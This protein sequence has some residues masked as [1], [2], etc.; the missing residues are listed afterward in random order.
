MMLETDGKGYSSK[1]KKH[2]NVRYFF[3]T[4]WIGSGVITVKHCPTGEMLGDHFMKPVQGNHFRKFRAHTQ[5]IKEDTPYTLLG[6]DRSCTRPTDPIPHEC[7][8][9][10]VKVKD[11]AHADSAHAKPNIPVSRG[12]ATWCT[13]TSLV[14]SGYNVLR[15]IHKE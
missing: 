10:C 9:E 6:W 1:R 7:V 4:D 14:P 8:G 5:G 12:Q 11:T 2:I 15:S 13:K 3:I